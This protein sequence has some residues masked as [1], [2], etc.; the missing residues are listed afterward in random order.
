MSDGS[1]PERALPADATVGIVGPP[2]RTDPVAD[3]AAAAGATVDVA[4]DVDELGEVAALVAVGESTAAAV[5]RSCP[6]PPLLAV[7]AGPGFGSIPLA[8]VE[9]AVARL[10]DGTW[11]AREHP[12]VGLAATDDHGRAAV[13][14][15]LVTES[16]ARISEYAIRSAG[17]TVA[18]VRADGIAVALPVGS[19][20]YTRTADGPVLAPETGVAAVVSIAPYTTDPDH[21]VVPVESLS[22]TVLREEPPVELLADDRT[23]GRVAP[24][25]PVS[26]EPAGTFRVVLVPES[27]SFFAV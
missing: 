16:P 14:A 6:S 9:Q 1:A 4:R 13:D 17:E 15:M 19:G 2:D 26:P 7:E 11:E 27:R 23:V 10:L 24:H 5:A 8:D 22:L 20:G 12:V 25:D 21:W 3:A 18:T